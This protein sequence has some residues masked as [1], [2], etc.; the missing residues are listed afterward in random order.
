LLSGDRFVSERAFKEFWECGI[1]DA[2]LDVCLVLMQWRVSFYR[3]R[4]TAPYH[5]RLDL[6]D[7]R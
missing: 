6:Q 7:W 3:R 1:V 2:A 4:C 5:G